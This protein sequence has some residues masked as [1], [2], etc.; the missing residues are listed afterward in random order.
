MSTTHLRETHVDHTPHERTDLTINDDDDPSD[1]LQ[2]LSSET[3]QAI[4]GTLRNEPK[5]VSDIA[6][7]VDTSLQNAQYHI[8]RL[9]KADLVEP[10]DVWYS[11]KGREMSVYALAAEE[12]LVQ[13]GSDGD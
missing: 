8:G 13:F 7:V 2:A 12:L 11:P 4:L 3:A 1:V 9:V 6:E 10:V 5:P